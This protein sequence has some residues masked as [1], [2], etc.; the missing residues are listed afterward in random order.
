MRGGRQAGAAFRQDA[1]DI[2]K[3]RDLGIDHG[4]AVG[5]GRFLDQDCPGDSGD[6]DV[7]RLGG[8]GGQQQGEQQRPGT[9]QPPDFRRRPGTVPRRGVKALPGISH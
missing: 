4:Q 1:L 2:E 5:A 7:V 8:H 3:R 6:I 9:A